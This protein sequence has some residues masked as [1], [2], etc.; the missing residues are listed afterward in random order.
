MLAE[1][2]ARRG[3]GEA[4]PDAVT[5]MSARKL[6]M[7]GLDC[8]TP[9][10]LFDRFA[11]DMPRLAE[12]LARSMWGPMRSIDP[13]ITV[14]AWSCMLSGRSPGELGIY[15]FRNR[16]DHS[17]DRLSI[18]TSEHV[19]VPRIW[20][21]LGAQGRDS[22]LLGVP[23]TYPPPP[24]RGCVVGDF[25]SPSTSVNWTYPSALGAEI[26]GLAGSYMLDVVNFR[27]EEKTRIAQQ[28]FDMTEQRFRVARHLAT[29]REWDLFAMVDMGPD[30]LHHGFWADCDPAHPRFD[31][32]GPR[33]SLFR[34]YY[35][36]LDRHLGA[37][38]ETFD[39][40][41]A[42]L[43]VSDHGAQ[44]M[45]GGFCINEWLRAEGLLTLR[46]EPAGRLPIAEAAIDWSRTAAWADGGYYARIFLNVAGREPEGSIAPADYDVIREQI[47][48][49]I[50]AVPD[51]EGRPMGTRAMRPEDLYP[52]VTGV[53]PDLLVY[54]G[55]LR[56]RSVG[57]LGLGQ[58]FYTFENDTG[59]DDANHADTGV[60][61]LSGGGID[62]GRS[63]DL[64]I[65]DVAPTIQALLGVPA[66]AGQRGRV[67]V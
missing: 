9:Q 51:H 12:L 49:A 57:T 48:R 53:A 44:P 29:T 31:P 40:D 67:L 16:V 47:A 66:P 55:D 52:E 21:L 8:A 50:E 10:L 43:V 63:D 34:D 32:A 60:F 14:P 20:D 65:Y 59:P 58:G 54:L 42:V 62:T 28:V 35:R 23:G 64:S 11:R 27:S 41:T 36:A 46:T 33:T 18:A 7:I 38:L 2:P 3:T 19:R 39:D 56:W 1:D 5:S 45:V 17:Y 22:V 13:P 6:A 4:I 24:V 26:E 25:L 30:R 15:G 61:A 37:L